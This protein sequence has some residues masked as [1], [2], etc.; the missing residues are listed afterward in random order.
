MAYV[1]TPATYARPLVKGINMTQ[2]SLTNK[3]VAERTLRI[4][5]AGR[6]LKVLSIIKREVTEM[7][8][9]KYL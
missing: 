2:A 8:G 7:I 6:V 9:G 3:A 5:S 1:D 4:G